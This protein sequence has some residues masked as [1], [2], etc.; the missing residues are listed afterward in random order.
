VIVERAG[1]LR[2][3]V[4]LVPLPAHRPRA[5]HPQV[6]FRDTSGTGIDL[7]QPSQQRLVDDGSVLSTTGLDKHFRE[8]FVD[9]GCDV[10]VDAERTGSAEGRLGAAQRATGEVPA[11]EFEEERGRVGRV[12]GRLGELR[13][14]G[15]PRPFESRVEGVDGVDGTSCQARPLG[16]QHGV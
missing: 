5:G 10:W 1:Q 3:S 14:Q 7:L 12:V 16:R 8:R 2:L 13:G 4:G 6:G 15:A 9:R 11:A